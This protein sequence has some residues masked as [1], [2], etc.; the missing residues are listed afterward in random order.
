MGK[1]KGFSL[2]EVLF[3]VFLMG[4]C[5][6]IVAAC[7][8]VANNSRAR[9]D[10]NNK[11]TSM[12]QKQLEAIRG[13]GYANA[14]A[15]QLYAKGLLD[16][17]TAIEGD[18]YTF[19]AVDTGVLDSPAYILPEGEGFVTIT[20]PDTDLRQIVVEVKWVDRGKEKTVQIGTM[21]ANL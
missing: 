6:A 15:E 1:R 3:A 10:L 7:M 13:L 12:A 5:A 4:V 11:A 19:T 2:I 8:P 21:V 20:Q 18:T 16:S 9:A 17:A 14:T